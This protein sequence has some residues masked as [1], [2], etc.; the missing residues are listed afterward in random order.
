MPDI[1]A[2]AKYVIWSGVIAWAKAIEIQKDRLI[3]AYN[4]RMLGEEFGDIRHRI[5]EHF[6]IVACARFFYFR[7]MSREHSLFD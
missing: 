6:F 1:S 4:D 3:S 5:E 2:E 7:Q